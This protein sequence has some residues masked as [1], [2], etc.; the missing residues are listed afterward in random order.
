MQTVASICAIERFALGLTLLASCCAADEPRRAGPPVSPAGAGAAVTVA[1]KQ[2]SA[3]PLVVILIVDQLPAWLLAERLELL[4]D[5]GGFARLQRGGLYA[6]E[7]RYEHATTSTAPGH[8]ALHTGLPS[9]SSGIYANERFDSAR[10]AVSIMAD[11]TS[12]LVIDGALPVSSSSARSLLVPTLADAL[13]EQRPS[14]QIFSFS[15]KD[16]S[17]I[18]GGGRHP[19]AS[20]WYDTSRGIFV[21]SSAFA[22]ALPTFV[23]DFNQGLGPRQRA[24]WTPLDAEWIAAHARTPDAQPGEALAGLGNVFPHDLGRSESPAALFRATPFADQALLELG[25][26]ALAAGKAEAPR[27]LVISLSAFDYVGHFF[28]PDSWESWD[29][30]LRLDRSLAAFLQDIE[31]RFG[32]NVS[33][34]LSADHGSPP[35]PET[36][37]NLRARPWCKKAGADPYQRP[38]TRGERLFRGPIENSL[39]TVAREAVGTGDWIAAVIEPFV[40]YTPAAKELP[41]GL[42]AKLDR[43]VVAGLEKTPGVAR[44]FP[45]GA[46]PKPC[47]L[48]SD[49]S[50]EALVC[51]SLSPNAG[52][53]YIVSAPGSFFDPGQDPGRGVNHGSPYLYDRAVPL[54]VRARGCSAGLV[55]STPVHPADFVRTAARLLGVEPPAAAAHGHDL[56]PQSTKALAQ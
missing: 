6:R 32:D 37:G 49:E 38:C 7:L 47:P 36:A 4:P 35:L 18:L 27:L 34:L 12:R 29:A 8:A 22:E 40:Y 14:A 41:S 42:R 54:L 24:S 26:S 11:D 21:T 50:I 15:L 44:A 51:R 56:C 3:A 1:A 19:N 20:V 13:R 16:R 25:L 2:T 33:V 23:R 10:K 28:G 52:D 55:L 48:A 31:R 5:D 45:V 17:A 30:L 43:A 46:L 9:G 39:H 53:V